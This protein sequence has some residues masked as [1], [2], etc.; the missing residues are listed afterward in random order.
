LLDEQHARAVA[1]DLRRRGHDVIAVT[2]RDDLRALPDLELLMLAASERRAVVTENIRDFAI[3]HRWLFDAGERHYGII[4]TARKRLPRSR[5][6][7]G[8]LVRALADFLDAH[9]GEDDLRDQTYWL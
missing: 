4:Y 9:P 3:V 7:R 1:A 6:L 2:E 8:R 5:K